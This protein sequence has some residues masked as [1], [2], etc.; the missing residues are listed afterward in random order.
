[1][2]RSCCNYSYYDYSFAYVRFMHNSEKNVEKRCVYKTVVPS[3]M[4]F[5]FHLYMRFQIAHEPTA[6]RFPTH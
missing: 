1:M 2:M 3:V 4:E 6:A 5:F